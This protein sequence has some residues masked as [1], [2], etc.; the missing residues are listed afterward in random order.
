MA[1]GSSI[2]SLIAETAMVNGRFPPEQEAFNNFAQSYVDESWPSIHRQLDHPA[3]AGPLGPGCRG[4]R[5]ASAAAM[6]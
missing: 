2:R 3:A 6:A 1:A 4:G 5:R